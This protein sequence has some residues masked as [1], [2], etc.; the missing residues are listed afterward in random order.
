MTIERVDFPI[1][2]MVIFPS[3]FFLFTRGYIHSFK[4]KKVE[5]LAENHPHES[6]KNLIEP[7]STS[8]SIHSL[9]TSAAILSNKIATV[10]WI[11]YSLQFFWG[12]WP[13]DYPQ[14]TMIIELMFIHEKM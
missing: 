7:V 10:P 4:K 12:T 5:N 14:I 6:L 2:S 9:W 13:S 3:V 1:N 11:M 8:D